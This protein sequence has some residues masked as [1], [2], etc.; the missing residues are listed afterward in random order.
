MLQHCFN[1]PRNRFL[2][3]L[4]SHEE[5]LPS[6]QAEV[7]VTHSGEDCRLQIEAALIKNGVGSPE[8]LEKQVQLE[9]LPGIIPESSPSPNR[10]NGRIN[11]GKSPHPG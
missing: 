4:D 10:R 1:F 7:G 11:S 3:N 9:S 6:S 5:V 2:R 8:G